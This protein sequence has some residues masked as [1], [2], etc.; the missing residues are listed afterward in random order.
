MSKVFWR[1]YLWLSSA[2]FILLFSSFP[3]F[4]GQANIF[5]YHRFG[6]NRYPSTNIALRNFEA[7]LKILQQQNLSVLTLGE[8]VACLRQGQSLPAAV[9]VLT[10]DDGY[11]SFLTG[12]MPLLR[13]YGYPA[14]L[15]ISTGSVGREGFLSWE[16]LKALSLQGIEIGNHSLSH[17]YLVEREASETVSQWLQRASDDIVAAQQAFRENLGQT[18]R[19]FSYP[20]GEAT[21]EIEALVKSL[22]FT[23][24][25][26]QQSGVVT[27]E[28]EMYNLPRF[29]MGGPYVS[30]ES[31]SSK[32]AMKALRVEVLSPQSPLLGMEN[33][34]LLKVTIAGGDVNLD[35]MRCFVSG[36]EDCLIRKDPASPGSY[37]VQAVE[38]LTSRRSKY[39]LTAPSNDGKTWYWFSR[40]WIQRG[41]RE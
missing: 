39:T 9:A 28:S 4:A 25:V 12:A 16:D 23:A 5:V 41:V 29:P 24:A 35:Q 20:Y 15:F 3:A 22:G 1:N 40:L 2:I 34:P 30:E 11:K 31:F 32:L 6:D 18:P 38:P 37:L 27:D 7:H 10:V 21:P 19:L 8:V 14:T 13:Q 36:Q 33:P 26:G 17:P